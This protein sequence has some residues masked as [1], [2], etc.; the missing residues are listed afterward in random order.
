MGLFCR[1]SS[2]WPIST[3]C[4]REYSTSS[5][6]PQE[7]KFYDKEEFL[8]DLTN[9]EY[10]DALCY[11][12]DH[13]L[14]NYYVTKNEKGLFDHVTA[15]DNDA[16]RTFFVLST[17]P[18]ATYAGASCVLAK[19]GTVARP[20]MD[21]AFADKLLNINSKDVKKAV[22]EYLSRTQLRCLNGR[23]KRLRKAVLKTSQ[24][25][26]FLVSSW[27]LAN[28][29]NAADAKWGKTYFEI[30]LNDTLMLDREKEFQKMRNEA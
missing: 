13:R 12:L 18:K 28:A 30:Y 4:Q 5:V 16:A 2:A 14:D 1:Y 17:L 20:Y 3:S 19:D 9:L 15:F 7:R 22:G 11:Q 24:R 29:E 6:M 10:F 23:I 21:K 25:R 27:E 26:D 8:K